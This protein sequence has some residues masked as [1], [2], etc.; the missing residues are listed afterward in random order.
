MAKDV[1]SGED[2]LFHEIY[3]VY[4]RIAAHM[5][6]SAEKSPLSEDKI[7]ESVKEFG[8]G[9]TEFE[10]FKKFR[11]GYIPIFN[12]N[13]TKTNVTRSKISLQQAELTQ[14]ET[15]LNIRQTIMQQYQNVVSAYNKYKVTDIRQ[16]AYSK[17]FDAFRAQFNAGSITPVELLQQQNNYISALND[18]IQNKYGFMLKR[19]ILVSAQSGRRYI[20][21]TDDSG[22]GNSIARRLDYIKQSGNFRR[23][24]RT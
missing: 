23:R 14:M 13:R 8:F 5:I 20:G 22:G 18:Y 11:N 17:S 24:R 1:A 12:K 7:K 2:V 10:F 9:E 6:E 3:N 15:E 19:K 21:M 16:N 4:Y